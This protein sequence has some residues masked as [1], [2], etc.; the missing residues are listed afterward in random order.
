MKNVIFPALAAALVFAAGSV[1]FQPTLVRAGDM[2][3]VDCGM[4]ENA[5][6][7][8]CQK[9]T[10][11]PMMKDDGDTKMKDDGKTKDDGNMKT[12]DDGGKMMKDEKN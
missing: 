8:A 9:M 6:D 11:D 12:K 2:P 7:P 4:A 1:A 10:G 3:K 5:N